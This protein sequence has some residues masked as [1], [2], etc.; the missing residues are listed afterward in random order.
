MS[1]ELCQWNDFQF[2]VMDPYLRD[3]YHTTQKG[4]PVLGCFRFE[5]VWDMQRRLNQ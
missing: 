2:P 3:Q 4:Y 1:C 5:P